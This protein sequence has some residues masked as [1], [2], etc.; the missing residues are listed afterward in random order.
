MPDTKAEDVYKIMLVGDSEVG[1]TKIARC[2][3][4]KD[5]KLEQHT[6]SQAINYETAVETV[7]G[8]KKKLRVYD[9]SGD[10]KHGNLL[11]SYYPGMNGFL[12]VFDLMEE[13]SFEHL[14]EKWAKSVKSKCNDHAK[15][16]LVGNK[17]DCDEYREVDFQ[18]AKDFAEVISTIFHKSLYLF[19]I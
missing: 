18:R 19:T 2:Y 11:S 13:S 17:L 6:P 14:C 10:D 16:T 1:K 5:R 7:N 3:H 4:H 9:T 12:L 15:F 8:V